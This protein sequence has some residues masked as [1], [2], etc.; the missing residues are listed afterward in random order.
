MVVVELKTPPPPN[1]PEVII[2]ACYYKRTDITNVLEN[3]T[4]EIMIEKH[5]FG[6]N[7]LFSNQRV[8]CWRQAQIHFHC[9]RVYTHKT[10]VKYKLEENL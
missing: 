2:Y 7:T 10:L 3:I 8:S 6:R 9:F 5:S 4:V 1:K